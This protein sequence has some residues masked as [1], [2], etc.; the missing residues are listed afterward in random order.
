VWI[1]RKERKYGINN[2][3]AKSAAVRQHIIKLHAGCRC[4]EP[5][6]DELLE[7]FTAQPLAAI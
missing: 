2:R 3:E 7:L 4:Q 5:L 6:F 1:P